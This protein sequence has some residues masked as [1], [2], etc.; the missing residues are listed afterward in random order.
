MSQ[1][2]VFIVDDDAAVRAS[3]SLLLETHGFRI[4][5]YESGEALLAACEPG[6]Q[7]CVVLD[8]RLKGMDGLQVLAELRRRG[9]SLPAIFLSGHGD[10]PT[11]VRA[12]KAGASEFLTKP[13]SG[14]QLIPLIRAAL[15]Q[16]HEAHVR[17]RADQAM[18]ER[19]ARL[20]QREQE[21]LHLVLAG[22]GNKDI[23]RMLSISHRTVE[24]HRSRI[25][26]KT[27]AGNMLEL[28]GQMSR[29]ELEE[30]AP[31]VSKPSA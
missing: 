21:V 30:P 27:Q 16:D 22:H 6:W 19:L 29:D 31:V 1:P 14:E 13:V 25:L 20:S 4:A 24:V 3:L 9:V 15:A 2:I 17:E 5:T 11:T 12:M 28:A 26:A 23:A 10:I 18:R 8:L 7:G